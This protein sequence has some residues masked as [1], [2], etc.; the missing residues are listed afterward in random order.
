MNNP[1]LRQE[2]RYEPAAVIPLKQNTS[3]LDWLSANKRLIPR[4]E[5]EIPKLEEE[6][7]FEGLIDEDSYTDDDDTGETLED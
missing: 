5:V 6:E 2:P 3:I 1:S 4:E 7:E